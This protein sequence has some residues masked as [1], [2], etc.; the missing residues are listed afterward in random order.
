MIRTLIVTAVAMLSI[1]LTTEAFAL[2]ATDPW[3]AAAREAMP[4]YLKIWLGLMMLNNIA[5]IAFLKNHVPARW[6]FAG[7]VISHGLVIVVGLQGMTVYAGQVSLF[8]ILFW[9][10]G[11]IALFFYRSKI[12]WPSAF[13]VWATLAGIF[14]CVSMIFDLRDATTWLFS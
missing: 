1:A 14:Y 3:D 5:T 6:W 13:A 2:S 12:R 7:F 8:H 10:P 11:A 9:T 4:I